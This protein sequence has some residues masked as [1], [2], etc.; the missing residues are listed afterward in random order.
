MKKNK[1]Q[2]IS[3]LGTLIA[4]TSLCISLP[5]ASC[6]ASSTEIIPPIIIPPIIENLVDIKTPPQNE[7][8]MLPQII[9]NFV[10]EIWYDDE[11]QNNRLKKFNNGIALNKEIICRNLFDTKKVNN[12]NLTL[13]TGIIG[14][15]F[16][17]RSAYFFILEFTDPNDFFV[18]KNE[19]MKKAEVKIF[20]NY[21]EVN[22]K[23]ILEKIF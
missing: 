21:L 8:D 15:N 2:K 20:Q 3:L 19:K 1:I 22:P 9:I 4:G 17:D 10:P 23:I 6:S 5:L 18:Y 13:K 11:I 7:K 12:F 16:T 14:N